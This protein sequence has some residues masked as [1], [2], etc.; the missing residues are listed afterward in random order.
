MWN[1]C[2]E[3]LRAERKYLLP[4]N[5]CKGALAAAIQAYAPKAGRRN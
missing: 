5:V 4:R 2:K 1:M 3:E